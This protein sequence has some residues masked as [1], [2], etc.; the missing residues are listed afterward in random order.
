MSRFRFNSHKGKHIDEADNQQ[1]FGHAILPSSPVTDTSLFDCASTSKSFTAAALALLVDDDTNFPHVKWNTPISHLLP[2]DF[3]LSESFYTQDVTIED[4]LSHRSGFPGHDEALMG[5]HAAH[6]DT[7]KSV[8]RNLRNLPINKPIRTTYQYSNIMYTVSSYLVEALSGMDFGSFLQTR[9]WDPL[10]M[11]NTFLQVGG[12]ERGGAQER[13][14]KGYRW[15]EKKREYIEVPWRSQHE[16]QGAGSMFSCASDYAKWIQCMMQQ[17]PPIS[18]NQ[19]K[20]L[21]K[22]RIIANPDRDAQRDS[23]RMFSHT[24]YALGWEVRTYRGHTTIGHDG[25]VSGYESKMV[26][27]PHL[28]WGIVIFGNANGAC[29]VAEAICYTLVDELL[30]VPSKDRLNWTQVIQDRRIEIEEGDQ[31]STWGSE[32]DGRL[33][34]SV[35][36]VE[37]AGSYHNPGYRI[38]TFIVEDNT[39]F[40]NCQERS[41]PFTLR[42]F[43]ASDSRFRVEF[44]IPSDD[45]TIRLKAQFQLQEDGKG[46]TGFGI[47]LPEHMPDDLIWFDKIVQ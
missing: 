43:H 29:E 19:H 10:G 38:M 20:E 30:E 17:S 15:D 11:T 13:L 8:T 47:N 45:Y 44:R 31:D 35:P 4:I 33:P 12:V 25:A 37:L 23:E 26:Y 32:V 16:G 18:L 27:L 24:L 46:V 42:L 3:V 36:L 34:L 40:A 2:Q 28:N 14:T 41:V 1:N 5:E 22:P 7:P 21:I 9:L 39:L 6:P